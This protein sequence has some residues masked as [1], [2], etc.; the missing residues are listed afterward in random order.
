MEE[1]HRSK[2]ET[3][4]L[5]YLRRNKN[6]N[7]E[8]EPEKWEYTVPASVHQYTPDIK[9]TLAS[10][11]VLYVELKGKLDINT[12]KKMLLVKAQHPDKDIRIVFMRNNKLTKSSKT[13]YTEWATKAG[14]IS[15]VGTIPRAWLAE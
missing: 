9:L 6:L 3:Y 4:V 12:R 2:F 11:S 15:A 1:K 14:F 8:Y 5:A 7:V 13:K 10:G